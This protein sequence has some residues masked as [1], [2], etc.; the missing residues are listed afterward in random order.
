VTRRSVAKTGLTPSASFF[1]VR[2]RTGTHLAQTLGNSLGPCSVSVS[3]FAGPGLQAGEQIVFGERS[4]PP[5]DSVA[6]SPISLKQGQAGPSGPNLLCLSRQIPAE[7][8][9]LLNSACVT[10]AVVLTSACWALGIGGF[11]WSV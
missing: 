7:V 11:C 3:A 9:K 2:L 1:R 10:A 6:I 4:L 8:S 5:L